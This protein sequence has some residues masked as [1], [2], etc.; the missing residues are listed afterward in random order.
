MYPEKWSWWRRD[1][2][3]VHVV[4]LQLLLERQDLLV[5][6]VQARRQRDHDV[7]LLQQQLLVPVNLPTPQTGLSNTALAEGCLPTHQS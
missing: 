1:A 6:L 2:L 3:L 7:P 5:A 4:G